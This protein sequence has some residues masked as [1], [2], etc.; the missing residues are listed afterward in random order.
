LKKF[1]IFILLIFIGCNKEHIPSYKINIPK[2]SKKPHI[3][4]ENNK[5]L[6]YSKINYFVFLHTKYIKECKYA[7]KCS[8]L[9]KLTGILKINANW[10][11]N[12]NLDT[13]Y[14]YITKTAT[15]E[16]IKK[17]KNLKIPPVYDRI[18]HIYLKPVFIDISQEERVYPYKNMLT[19]A[20]GVNRWCCGKLKSLSGLEKLVKN[21]PLYTTINIKQQ[22][23]LEK[24]ADNLKQKYNAK[25]VL[26][27][28]LNL[29]NNKIKAIASS[30]R[31]N[32]SKIKDII[33][34]NININRYLFK[35]DK[36]LNPVREYMK[37]TDE[38]N[39]T[40][41]FKKLHL[42]E[43]S[44]DLPNETVMKINNFINKKDFT[45]DNIKLNFIQTTKLYSAFINGYVQKL[46]VLKES[47]YKK[48][49]ILKTEIPLKQTIYLDF[50]K[51]REKGLLI[52]KKEYP[53]LKGY[54]IIG[55]K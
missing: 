41:I 12:K 46:S 51:K 38:K 20:I 37:K 54:F 40:K 31:Y 5:T 45:V 1:L 2:Y 25:E 13:R 3:L 15:K 29:T 28:L 19:P 26:A 30:N 10:I 34:T 27:I 32:P 4:S 18:H 23:N 33:S 11:L 48:E 22:V 7:N 14:V 24:E 39:L 8:I 17:L 50:N 21:K 49:K 53:Y 52:F 9:N 42:F 6:T 47:N 36:L 35:S 44:S 16:D 43:L 55:I